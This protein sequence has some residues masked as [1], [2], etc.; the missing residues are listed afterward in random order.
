MNKRLLR[1]L[2]RKKNEMIRSYRRSKRIRLRRIRLRKRRRKGNPRK[3]KS[4]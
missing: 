2:I 1:R 4:V 3:N